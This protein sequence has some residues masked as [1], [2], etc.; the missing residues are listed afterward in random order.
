MR[1]ERRSVFGVCVFFFFCSLF[2]FEFFIS[3]S[4]KAISCSPWFLDETGDD[5]SLGGCHRG[6]NRVSL[7][8]CR[9]GR[10]RLCLGFSRRGRDRLGVGEVGIV[11]E[12]VAVVEEGNQRLSP[13]LWV[14]STPKDP[15]LSLRRSTGM[16]SPSRG[17]CCRR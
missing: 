7:G 3:V 6:R 14:S 15:S 5:G 2:L 4:E 9:Q 10:N 11:S 17:G 1:G 12:S 16:G 13:F 8:G